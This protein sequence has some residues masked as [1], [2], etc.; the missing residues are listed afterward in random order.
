MFLKPVED[1]ESLV[2]LGGDA[3][4]RGATI[5]TTIA[6][7]VAGDLAVLSLQRWFPSYY[8]ALQTEG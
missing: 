4:R 1:V 3:A 5:V 2:A 8:D 6:Y 7:S